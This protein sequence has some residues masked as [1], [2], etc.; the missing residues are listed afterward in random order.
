[1]TTCSFDFLTQDDDTRV[2]TACIF[3]WAYAIPLL[4]IAIFYTKLFNHIMAHEKMLKDQ[5]KKMNVQSLSNKDANSESV[6][7]RI[8]KACFTIF[9]LYVC[10]WTPY[11]IVALIGSFGNQSLLTPVATMIPAVCAKIVSCIDRKQF[12]YHFIIYY[13]WTFLFPY[14]AWVYAISH[15][16][17]RAVLEK[18]VAWMGIKE[19]LPDE[20]KSSS[21]T[22]TSATADT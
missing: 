9:F 21:S 4:F 17:Y 19:T 15:P 12:I 14:A 16:R 8:A 7:L 5:A 6:E 18:R 2:F 22:A 3:V 1:L 11:A 13:S 10:A 20:S